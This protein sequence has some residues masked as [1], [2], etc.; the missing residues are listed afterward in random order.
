MSALGRIT[1]MLRGSAV[2]TPRAPA[3]HAGF[4]FVVAA[5]DLVG[6]AHTTKIGEA[7]GYIVAAVPGAVP[8]YIWATDAAGAEQRVNDLAHASLRDK[9]AGNGW[10][11]CTAD[12]AWAAIK[13]AA[14]ACGFP[15][16]IK[17]DMQGVRS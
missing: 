10:Y 13:A 16:S 4:V 12:D 17:F 9:A 5:D 15:D 7:I 2:A 1:K 11:R 14:A 3:Q 8:K 6:I